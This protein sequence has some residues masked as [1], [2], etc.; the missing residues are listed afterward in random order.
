MENAKIAS[1]MESAKRI[2]TDYCFVGIFVKRNA[3]SHAL[4]AQRL[5]RLSAPIPN[6]NLYVEFPVFLVRN[7]VLT[8][9]LIS[10]V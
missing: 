9:V 5:V 7:L 10:N 3:L 1:F 2:A 6:A 4:V 8:I